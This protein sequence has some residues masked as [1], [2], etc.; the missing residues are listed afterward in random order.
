MSYAK[1]LRR[2]LLAAGVDGHALHRE[3][4][5]SPVD[6]HNTRW[7]YATALGQSGASD[8]ET[9]KLGG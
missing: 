5:T 4:V 6:F 1:C 2:E 7:V 8:R 3:T 9:M